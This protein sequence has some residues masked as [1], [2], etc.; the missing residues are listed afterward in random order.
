LRPCVQ[1]SPLAYDC[2]RAS[3]E[4][5]RHTVPGEQAS[6]I[7]HLRGPAAEKARQAVI[8]RFYYAALSKHL[9]R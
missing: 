8:V 4:L 9:D 3:S 6:V 7:T 5:R 1:D 2:V